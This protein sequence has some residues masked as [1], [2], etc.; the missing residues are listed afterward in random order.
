MGRCR[1]TRRWRGKAVAAPGRLAAL[2]LM[3][4]LAVLAGPTAAQQDGELIIPPLITDPSVVTRCIA[5][6]RAPEA[7]IG[8]MTEVCIEENDIANQNLEERRC[9]VAEYNTWSALAAAEAEV[10]TRFAETMP[11]DSHGPLIGDPVPL[12]AAAAE[13]WARFAQAECT[14]QRALYGRGD[15]RAIAEDL[16]LRQLA[17][18]RY[19]RLARLNLQLGMK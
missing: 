19:G 5:N 15:R 16:C 9:I 13:A 14:A 8:A 3:A 11:E 1:L 17:A 12:L 7:C 2:A 18:E 4:A 6:S 10:L